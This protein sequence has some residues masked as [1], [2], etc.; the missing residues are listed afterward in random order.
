ME[1]E[2]TD[3]TLIR[4]NFLTQPSVAAKT[5]AHLMQKVLKEVREDNAE[6]AMKLVLELLSV[7]Q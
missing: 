6:E 5:L 1:A 2:E 4:T 7:P 3:L